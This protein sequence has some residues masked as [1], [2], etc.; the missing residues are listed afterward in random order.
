MGAIGWALRAR[1]ADRPFVQTFEVL[2]GRGGRTRLVALLVVVL[3]IQPVRFWIALDAV[4]LDP[5]AV[6]ALVTFLITNVYAILPIGP[7]PSSVG[8]AATIFGD[9]QLAQAGAA[10]LILASSAVMAAALYSVYGGVAL[11]RRSRTSPDSASSSRDTPS[12]PAG[13]GR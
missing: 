6:E 12:V 3:L 10:G 13:T 4:G 7:G 9:G 5:S 1:F 11:A 8:A 2:R